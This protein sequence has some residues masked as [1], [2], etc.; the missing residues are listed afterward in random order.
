[1]AVPFGSAIPSL[2]TL[3]VHRAG[4][5]VQ[6]RIWIGQTGSAGL[7]GQLH[8]TREDW[9]L[10]RALL[11]EYDPKRMSIW[12]GPDAWEWLQTGGA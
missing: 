1:M 7:C 11:P 12:Y 8:M 9:R 5:H 10:F 6:V 4:D 2:V 3:R